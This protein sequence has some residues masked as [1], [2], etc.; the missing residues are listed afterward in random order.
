[1]EGNYYDIDRCSNSELSKIKRELLGEKGFM[2]GE[3]TLHF[4]KMFHVALLEPEKYN[5]ALLTQKDKVLLGSMMEQARKCSVLQFFLSNAKTEKEAEKFFEFHG[6]PFKAKADIILGAWG[7]DP[8]TTSA[9][10]REAFIDTFDDYGYW[11]Q[12]VIYMHAWQLNKFTF[13]GIR[14]AENNGAIYTVNAH[15]FPKQ[16]KEAREE[17]EMLTEHYIHRRKKNK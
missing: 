15:D 13:F 4:G 14:K 11:R 3:A 12:A 1:M 8:K 7:A 17:A 2:A 5:P 16:L 9:S 6:A 10:S